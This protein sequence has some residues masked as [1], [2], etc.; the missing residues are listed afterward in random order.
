MALKSAIYEHLR[1]INSTQ[2]HSPSTHPAQE[3]KLSGFD[4]TFRSF[5]RPL[6]ALAPVFRP[7]SS[8]FYKVG[9]R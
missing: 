9:F 7:S 2:K 6:L 4:S 5:F 8:N 1:G 3:K